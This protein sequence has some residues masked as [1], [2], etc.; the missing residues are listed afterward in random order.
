MKLEFKEI[1]KQRE[2]LLKAINK[3]DIDSMKEI[4]TDDAAWIPP[5]M[6]ALMGKTAIVD[7]M[8]PFFEN[9]DYEFNVENPDVRGAGDWAVEHSS[10]VSKVAP[11][12]G[13]EG[14]EQH[15][16]YIMIWRWEKD[17]KWRIEKYLDTSDAQ[18]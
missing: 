18:N 17:N 3:N 5:G 11:K 4:L 15:G 6:P 8:N 1:Q 9:Y 10:F 16:K 14:T 2:R 13:G 12:D 7:W